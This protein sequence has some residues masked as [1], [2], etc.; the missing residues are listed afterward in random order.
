M[1]LVPH[2][3]IRH[4]AATLTTREYEVWYAH[5]AEGHSTR[6]IAAALH[7]DRSTIRETLT[8]AERKLS[9]FRIVAVHITTRT[10]PG[11]ALHL[12]PDEWED[13][14]TTAAEN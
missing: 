10:K 14:A 9:R 6:H 13:I 2:T 3:T 11:A 4:A 1:N 7:R 5:H 12:T 8:R